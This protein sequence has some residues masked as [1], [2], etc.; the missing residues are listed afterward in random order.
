MLE[1]H[2]H[3]Q[4]ISSHQNLKSTIGSRKRQYICTIDE[5]VVENNNAIPLEDGL[6]HSIRTLL[7]AIQ[8]TN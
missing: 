1:L 7:S 4:D 2:R 8:R 6:A 5:D 3:T